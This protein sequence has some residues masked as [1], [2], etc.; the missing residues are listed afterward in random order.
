[1][2]SSIPV[3]VLIGESGAGEYRTPSA[4]TPTTEREGMC[5]LPRVLR[6]ALQ[7]GAVSTGD[8]LSTS[9]K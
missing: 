6:E 1:M 9:T 3:K 2:S 5:E 8:A 7:A 4:D